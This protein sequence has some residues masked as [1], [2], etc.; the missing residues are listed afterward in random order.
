VLDVK[1]TNKEYRGLIFILMIVQ[2]IGLVFFY[3]KIVETYI[4]FGLL[5]LSWAG[6]LELYRRLT[7]W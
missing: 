7:G 1:L 3:P 4:G 5:G 6:V 2:V